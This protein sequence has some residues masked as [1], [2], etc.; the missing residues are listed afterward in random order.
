MQR[1]SVKSL[2]ENTW[3]KSKELEV[4]LG[5]QNSRC[6][7]LEMVNARLEKELSAAEKQI[8]VARQNKMTALAQHESH[9][10]DMVVS[11]N[12]Y[13]LLRDEVDM[14]SKC[15]VALDR[16][17]TTLRRS[18]SIGRS[19]HETEEFGQATRRTL[20]EQVKWAS[21]KTFSTSEKSSRWRK[22]S[23]RR[24]RSCARPSRTSAPPNCASKV[25]ESALLK[26]VAKGSA[27]NVEHNQRTT[28]PRV[29]AAAAAA[30]TASTARSPGARRQ[31]A[32]AA[33]AGRRERGADELYPGGRR[34]DS[35][36]TCGASRRPTGG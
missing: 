30:S 12:T 1:M 35:P 28:L 23:R 27:G 5:E 21:R 17:L 24:V 26:A 29:A 34:R 32:A 4:A 36:G 15:S 19:V 8:E 9:E 7:H 11:Q 16:T 20:S 25:N 6:A 2:L 31:A 13:R 10:E 18:V 33:V 22:F 14:H 3:S